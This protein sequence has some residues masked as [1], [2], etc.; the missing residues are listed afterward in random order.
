MLE[1]APSAFGQNAPSFYVDAF[2][3]VLE[4]FTVWFHEAAW[5]NKGVLSVS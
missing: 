1:R 3:H 5:L 4:I 2:D